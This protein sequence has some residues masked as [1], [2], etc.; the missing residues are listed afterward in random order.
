[1]ETQE[2][3]LATASRAEPVGQAFEQCMRYTGQGVVQRRL[4][5]VVVEIQ[6]G[7]GRFA[8]PALELERWAVMQ[9]F[10]VKIEFVEAAAPFQQATACARCLYGF[11]RLQSRQ[12]GRASWR[13]RG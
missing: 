3:V 5:G 8:W 12:I 6:K 4:E 7:G 1:M 11:R 10:D 13:E 9:Q 2:G